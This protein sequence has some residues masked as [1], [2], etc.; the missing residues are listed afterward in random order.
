MY[1]VKSY[2]KKF[3][4]EVMVL[5]R[6][7]DTH[8]CVS[9]Y[10]ICMCFWVVDMRKVPFKLKCCTLHTRFQW[11]L[12]GHKKCISHAMPACSSRKSGSHHQGPPLNIDFDM[13]HQCP[14]YSSTRCCRQ[15]SVYSTGVF[16]LKTATLL[17]PR[18]HLGCDV[19]Q[20]LP[21]H[22]GMII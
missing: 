20:G 22:D 1:T 8:M 14:M 18:K 17:L 2:W 3:A 21:A 6:P 5:Y 11:P 12:Q 15:E 9:A 19:R 13:R 7:R 16:R 4:L 10:V